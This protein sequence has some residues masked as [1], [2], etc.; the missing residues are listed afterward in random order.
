MS[1]VSRNRK[2]VAAAS[3]LLA[4][5][6]AGYLLHR[7]LSSPRWIDPNFSAALLTVGQAEPVMLTEAAAYRLSGWLRVHAH[8]WGKPL[9]TPPPAVE[10]DILLAYPDGRQVSLTFH[11]GNCLIARTVEGRQKTALCI[12]SA[13]ELESI[14]VPALMA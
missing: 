12:V 10:R 2:L 14:D 11:A 8:R 5:A 7:R 1:S 4:S 3:L 6:A 13:D 9:F